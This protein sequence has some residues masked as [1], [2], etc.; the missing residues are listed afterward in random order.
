MGHREALLIA[1]YECWAAT[2]DSG[3]DAKTFV[4]GLGVP[5]V[6][7]AASFSGSVP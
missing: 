7:R 1:M 6:P 3:H 5:Q 2:D 4:D